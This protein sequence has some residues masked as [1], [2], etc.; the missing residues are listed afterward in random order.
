[1]RGCS[2]FSKL[3]VEV[4]TA[5]Q[6]ERAH[7]A[8]CGEPS[9]T[10]HA[11]VTCAYVKPHAELL[12]WTSYVRSV[13][14]KPFATW[15]GSFAL[16]VTSSDAALQQKRSLMMRLFCIVFNWSHQKTVKFLVPKIVDVVT[17]WKNARIQP[18]YTAKKTKT[19][20]ILRLCWGGAESEN[21]PYVALFM[22]ACLCN[23]DNT[24]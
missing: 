19:L 24:F 21:S 23:I 17:K 4:V 2:L 8:C 9:L 12:C 7:E 11:C 16:D 18:K 15:N 14:E 22:F 13:K 5:P 10:L 6:K 1:M 20:S 3:A